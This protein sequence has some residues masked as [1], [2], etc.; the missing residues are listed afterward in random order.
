[1]RI[2]GK[3]FSVMKRKAGMTV[4]QKT[5]DNNEG[6]R[7]QDLASAFLGLMNLVSTLRSPGGCPWDAQQT[8]ESVKIYILEEAYEVL[9][10][11]ERGSAQN[12]CEE[13]GDLLFQ[14]LFLASIGE[15]ENEFDLLQVM[16]GI[17]KK[18]I[19][20]HPHVFGTAKVN[21]AK[22][23]AENWEKIKK[24]EKG[25]PESSPKL[26]M[27]VPIGLP[28]LLRAHRLAERA[29]KLEPGR[30]DGEAMMRGVEE[31]CESLRKQI[32]AGDKERIGEIIGTLLFH[33]A[34]LARH[35]GW[36]A[37]SLLRKANQ[38]FLDGFHDEEGVDR[39]PSAGTPR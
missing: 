33:L 23:V 19:N 18:M 32:R 35:W 11:I 36:N 2:S 24:R 34:D 37:E 14:I 31:S 12:L 25:V 28:A 15:D 20:R 21:S 7:R 10:A 29:S 17:T 30:A 26:I 4:H 5:R 16:Q 38:A 1:M 13:L 9:D 39:A 27:D 6:Q 22:E 8:S 3:R